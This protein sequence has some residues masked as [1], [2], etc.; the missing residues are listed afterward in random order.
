MN[1]MA[2]AIPWWLSWKV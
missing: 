1:D 2:V